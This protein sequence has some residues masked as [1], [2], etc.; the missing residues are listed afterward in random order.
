ML[1]ICDHVW[2]KRARADQSCTFNPTMDHEHMCREWRCV[3][4]LLSLILGT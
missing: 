4:A 1:K 3:K 2:Y